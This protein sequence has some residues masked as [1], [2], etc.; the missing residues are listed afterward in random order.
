MR[1][2]LAVLEDGHAMPKR[3]LIRAA[4]RL[5][6]VRFD[7]VLRTALYRPSFFGRSWLRFAPSLLRGPSDW[8]PGERELLAAFVSRR[9]ECPYCVGVHTATAALGLARDVDVALLDGWRDAHLDPRMRGAFELLE[10]RAT[11]PSRLT[12]ADR[13]L[14]HTAGLTDAAI[15]D[16]LSVGFMFDLVN[17]LANVFG[18]STVDE[19][20]RRKSAALLHRMGYRVPG[21]LLR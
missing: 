9:N 14:A 21:I 1:L 11:D 4:Q 2:R 18:F 3:L 5:G 13:A 16:A 8:S 7:D 10:R 19:T 12:P 6:G 15:D 20:G 17:R